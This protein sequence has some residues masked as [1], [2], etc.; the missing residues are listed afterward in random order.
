MIAIER[1]FFLNYNHIHINV[2]G[3]GFIFIFENSK[4]PAPNPIREK[5]FWTLGCP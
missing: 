3:K 1:R 2:F 4:V 5:K